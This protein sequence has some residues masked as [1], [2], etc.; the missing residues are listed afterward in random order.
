MTNR[1]SVGFRRLPG[2][3][4]NESAGLNDPVKSAPIDFKIAFDRKCHCPERFDINRL[5]LFKGPHMKLTG[6]GIRE[7]T[8][9]SSVD[10]YSTLP[11]DTLATVVI[12]FHRPFFL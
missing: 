4:G 7:G 6:G 8:V 5:A 2:A 9:C 3:S 12:E 10:H 1:N 11:T